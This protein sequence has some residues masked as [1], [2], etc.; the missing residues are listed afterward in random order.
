MSRPLRVAWLGHTSAELGGGMATYSREVVGGLDGGAT[1]DPVHELVLTFGGQSA[2]GGKNALFAY[3]VY[4]NALH[5]LPA[6][7]PPPERDGMG[8]AY[9]VRRQQ[10]VMFG[11]QYLPDERTWTYDFRASHWEPHELEPHPPGKKVTEDY[12]TIPR[13]AYDP[14]HG[15]VLCLA[16]LGEKGHETWALDAGEMRWRKMDPGAL[17]R[18]L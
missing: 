12:T 8:L 7:S 4:S 11:S 3:D 10:L 15:V 5:R 17:L 2:G 14:I 6:E 1:Y 18:S 9:D 13:L 16:W